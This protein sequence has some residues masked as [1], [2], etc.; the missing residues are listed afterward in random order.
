[1]RDIRVQLPIFADAGVQD[2]IGS[3]YSAATHTVTM[4]PGSHQV[5]V[6]LGRSAKPTVGVQVA[7]TAPGQHTLP[8][9]TSGQPTTATATVTNTG[10][11]TI[12]N[13]TVTAA[14]P[15]GWASQATSP[16]SFA[17]SGPGQADTGTWPVTPP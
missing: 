14:V 10:S 16:A 12:R 3:S 1:G 13:A 7:S 11:T 9:L 2:V 5:L 6:R 8:T 15:A 4:L 17:A